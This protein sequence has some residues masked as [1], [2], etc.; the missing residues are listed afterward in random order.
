METPNSL[1]MEGMLGKYASMVK[2]PMA[3]KPANTNNN[4]FESC[5]GKEV[6]L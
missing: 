2:G 4:N 5:L 3:T 1:A 6:V